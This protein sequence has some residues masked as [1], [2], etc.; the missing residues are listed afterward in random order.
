MSISSSSARL[1]SPTSVQQMQPEFN[2]VIWMPESRMKPL[3]TPTSPYSFSSSTT[4]SSPK[5]PPSSFLI[6]VVLPAPRKPEIILIFVIAY[7]L[8]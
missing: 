8:S 2:S 5:A 1:K 6:S 3:S 4:F 7:H